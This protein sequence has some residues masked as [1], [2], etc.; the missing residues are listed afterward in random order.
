MADFVFDYGRGRVAEK[1]ADAASNL[2][3]MLLKVSEGDATLKTRTDLANILANGN[4]EA[5]FTN[6]ARKTGLTGT[7]TVD[8]AGHV[9][10]VSVPDQTWSAAGG[11]ANDTLVKLIVYYQDSAADSGR[12]P[13]VGLDFAVTT[14][15]TDLGTTF[16]ASGF[17]QAS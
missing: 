8:T 4:T 3:I 1:V 16:N 14:D 5:V 15:G 13:L 17:W 7:V 9:V 12:I 6:Y 11:A 10:K 2:G